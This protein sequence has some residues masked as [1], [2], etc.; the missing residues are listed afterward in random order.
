[1]MVGMMVVQVM[2]MMR[3]A[4]AHVFS[5]TFLQTVLYVMED[6]G[7]KSRSHD[8]ERCKLKVT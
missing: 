2:A 1:M 4:K 8:L 5:L 6:F 3:S 7:V